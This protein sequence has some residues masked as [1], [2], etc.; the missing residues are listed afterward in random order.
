M[1]RDERAST[2]L[3]SNRPVDDWGKRLGDTAAR[4]RPAGS[5][6]ASWPCPQVRATQLA[7]E[8]PVRLAH[9]GG[10]EGERHQS[11]PPCPKWPVLRCRLMAAF[12]VSTEGELQTTRELYKQIYLR[13]S[14]NQKESWDGDSSQ[15]E[16]EVDDLFQHALEMRISEAADQNTKNNDRRSDRY[17]Y[18]AR[19]R[20]L[21]GT[22][23]NRYHGYIL[24]FRSGEV[25]RCRV[26][27]PRHRRRHRLPN[28]RRL[29]SSL[30]CRN[31][32]RT[33]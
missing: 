7:H 2:L 5:P 31:F 26:K 13:E 17:L 8:D 27:T 22:G 30:S 12:E 14:Y 25:L 32:P 24:R 20:D 29:I 10:H 18:W 3:T 23:F 19:V 33:E 16:Q 9:H 4:H 11:Q 6:A 15:Q 21:R 1:R 28:Q